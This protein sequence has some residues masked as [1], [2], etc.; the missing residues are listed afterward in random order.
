MRGEVP[1]IT[2]T[3]AALGRRL[4]EQSGGR[5]RVLIGVAGEPG[6]GKSTTAHGLV[7]ALAGRAIAVPMDGFHLANQV[8]NDLRLENRKGAIETFDLAGYA[9]LLARV[10]AAQESVVYAPS[11]VRGVE[12]SIAGAIAVDRFPSSSR[13]A[14]IYCRTIQMRR[15][16]VPSSMSGGI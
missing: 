9:A 16:R 5:D 10:R 3:I 11:Y 2:A 13:K 4:L 8:L 6:A 12:E 14:T 1:E 7:S 15:G